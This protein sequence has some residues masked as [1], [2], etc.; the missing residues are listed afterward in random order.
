MLISLWRWLLEGGEHSRHSMHGRHVGKILGHGV[1]HSRHGHGHGW[2]PHWHSHPHGH[3]SMSGWL[4]QW[5]AVLAVVQLHHLVV[6]HGVHRLQVHLI[7]PVSDLG[8]LPILIPVMMSSPAM[9]SVISLSLVWV[10]LRIIMRMMLIAMLIMVVFLLS[11]PLSMMEWLL[12]IAC[13]SA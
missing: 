13:F 10:V 2:D 8:V 1:G 12:L 4:G 5:H 7:M 6:V 9:L 11:C 3:V